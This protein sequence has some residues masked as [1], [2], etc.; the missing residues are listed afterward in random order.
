MERKIN[1]LE[2]AGHKMD[3]ETFLTHV[4][5]FIPQE[6]YQDTILTLKT[7]LREDDLSIEEAETLLDDKYNAMKEVQR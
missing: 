7:K 5:A 6:E 3:H 2:N 1:E 4:M